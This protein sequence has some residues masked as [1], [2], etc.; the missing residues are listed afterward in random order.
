MRALLT[1]FG[2]VLALAPMQV[3][4]Q[5]MESVAGRSSRP[6]LPIAAIEPLGT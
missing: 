6:S 1:L 4:A 3:A 2:A 5:A